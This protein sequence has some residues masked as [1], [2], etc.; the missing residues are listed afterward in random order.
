MNT[1]I[2]LQIMSR[3]ILS[4]EE[5]ERVLNIPS[6]SEDDEDFSDTESDEDIGKIQSIQHFLSESL[7]DV[8]TLSSPLK[9]QC[10]SPANEVAMTIDNHQPEAPD[11]QPRT[12]GVNSGT[13]RQSRAPRR[14]STMSN[15]LARRTR[16]PDSVTVTKRKKIRFI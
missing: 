2:L 11:P 4:N 6:G 14:S 10:L 7:S 1:L 8:E 5:I 9:H 12:L 16:I 3:K 15:V 13:L